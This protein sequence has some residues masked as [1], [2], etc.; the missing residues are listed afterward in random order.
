MSSPTK[1]PWELRPV[2]DELLE[3]FFSMGPANLEDI[4]AHLTADTTASAQPLSSDSVSNESNA[5]LTKGKKRK[6][7]QTTETSSQ[8]TSSASSRVAEDLLEIIGL[9]DFSNALRTENESLAKTNEALT[10]RNEALAKTNEA[11]Q[12]QV[13]MLLVEKENGRKARRI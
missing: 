9:N 13:R 11:L 5:Y 4:T 2:S 1:A 8:V 12:A 6:I 10:E 3:S 7:S